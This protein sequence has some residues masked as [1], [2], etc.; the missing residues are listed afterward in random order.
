M[1]R[2]AYMGRD[3]AGVGPPTPYDIWLES[4]VKHR[5]SVLIAAGMPQMLAMTVA[6]NE[7][8]LMYQGYLKSLSKA[9]TVSTLP[10]W[11]VP[12]G[13]GVA[14]LVIAFIVGT[15]KR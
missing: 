1:R 2:L 3:V 12:L 6:T 14:V 7:A 4:F 9:K 11:V 13:V 15:R 8:P 10:E 5:T